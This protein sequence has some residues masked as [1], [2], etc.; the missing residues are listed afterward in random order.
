L[1]APQAAASERLSTIGHL[2]TRRDSKKHP[3]ILPS[4]IFKLLGH[5][6]RS[7]ISAL[8]MA[9]FFSSPSFD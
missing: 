3:G 7:V 5:L 8:A 4:M 1:V 6:R 9:M 2:R